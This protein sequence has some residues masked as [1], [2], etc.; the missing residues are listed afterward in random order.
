MKKTVHNSKF[1]LTKGTPREDVGHSF[2]QSQYGCAA[3]L[4]PFIHLR[5]TLWLGLQMSNILL[6]GIIFSF[7]AT[8]LGNICEIFKFNHSFGVIFVKIWHSGRG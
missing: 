6:L 1:E 2:C 7:W 4:D 3:P 5:Y 8:L